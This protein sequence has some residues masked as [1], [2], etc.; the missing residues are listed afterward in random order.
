MNDAETPM[1]HRI[2]EFLK[3]NDVTFELF[4]HDHVHSSA[5]AA[6]VRGTNL[7]EAA[8]A[9]VLETG[10][11]RLIQCIVSGH[12]KID[13]KKLKALLGEKNISLAHPDNVLSATGCP[14]GT[15]PPLGNLFDPPLPVYADADIFTRH[16]VVFSAG[17]HYRSVRMKAEDWQR[18]VQPSVFDIG[19]D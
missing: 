5:D 3:G 7:E 1:F 8:K 11:G 19:K 17:S 16:H 4:D 12:R 15:V 9:L 10:S 6:K 13:L 18:L 2:V 14:V